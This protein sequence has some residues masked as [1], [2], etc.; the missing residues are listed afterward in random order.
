M[1]TSANKTIQKLQRI[2]VEALQAVKAQELVAFNTEHLSPLFERVVIA[3]GSSNRQVKAL[4]ARVREAVREA[5]FA[6]LRTEGEANGEWVIVDCGALVVHIMQPSFRQ[7]YKLEELW[8]EKPVRLKFGSPLPLAATVASRAPSA[9]SA[10]S[11]A[12][13]RLRR[14]LAAK[15]SAPAAAPVAAPAKKPRVAAAVASTSAPARPARSGVA[16]KVTPKATSKVV[17]ATKAAPK[18]A[19]Q[20]LHP[21]QVSPR[22]KRVTKTP[23]VGA[24]ESRTAAKAK[25]STAKA[26]ASTLSKAPAR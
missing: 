3:S 18:T 9:P 22:A 13:P 6:G 10:P 4:S 20:A 16:K 24:A 2:V 12:A 11:S 14:S 17:T 19:P 1:T 15:T 23:S 26:R 25:P 21:A 5:G 7:Y 8:G